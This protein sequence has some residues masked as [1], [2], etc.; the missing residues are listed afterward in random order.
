MTKEIGS[1]YHKFKIWCPSLDIRQISPVESE[2]S[3][4][5]QAAETFAEAIDGLTRNYWIDNPRAVVY[6]EIDE[7][8][9]VEFKITSKLTRTYHAKEY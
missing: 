4:A 3:D 8:D 9:I 7:K 5:K 2:G 1:G 6:V